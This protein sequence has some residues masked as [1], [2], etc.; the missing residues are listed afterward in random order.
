[1]ASVLGQLNLV[2]KAS[3]IVLFT[4]FKAQTARLGDH[5]GN[6]EGFWVCLGVPGAEVV[7]WC[8]VCLELDQVFQAVGS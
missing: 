6:L 2:P 8:S 3:Y 7:T 1:M 5:L 4:V